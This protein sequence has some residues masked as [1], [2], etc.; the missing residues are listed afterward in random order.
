MKNVRKI[1]LKSKK[2]LSAID[3]FNGIRKG[4]RAILS[5]AITLIESSNNKHQNIAEELIELCL[6]HSGNSVIL[7]HQNHI[8]KFV[9]IQARCLGQN[10]FQEQS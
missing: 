7:S 3:Y 6:P 9:M 2:S 5:K 1:S 4:N 10:G 8:L